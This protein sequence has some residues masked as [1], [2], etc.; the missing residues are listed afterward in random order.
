MLSKL[1]STTTSNLKIKKVVLNYHFLDTGM[2][3]PVGDL[4][5][6]ATTL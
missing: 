1:T 5:F 4:H 3:I 2:K 6:Q